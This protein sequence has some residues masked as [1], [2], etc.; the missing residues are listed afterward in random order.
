VVIDDAGAALKSNAAD[1]DDG[2]DVGG[3]GGVGMRVAELLRKLCT[4][5]S[6]LARRSS[7]LRL[8]VLCAG[9]ALST[10]DVSA[11]L[12]RPPGFDHLEGLPRPSE[13]ERGL[14][15]ASLAARARLGAAL[16]PPSRTPGVFVHACDNMDAWGA[17]VA[18]LTHGR[19]PGDLAGA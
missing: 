14:L 13:R 11:A 3:E 9:R 12:A 16:V 4:L 10:A 18:A 19:S 6:A 2:A 7:P 15:L 17:A 1:D 8:V 5:A